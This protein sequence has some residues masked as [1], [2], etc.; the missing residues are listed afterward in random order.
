MIVADTGA[1]IAL[2]DADDR[3]HAV[4]RDL[5]EQRPSAWRIPWAVLPEADYLILTHL[6]P[7]TEQAFLDDLAE[8]RLIVDWGGEAD[9][10]RARALCA[11]YRD[12]RIG[13]VDAVVIAVAERRRA[14]SIAT[15]DL[16]HFGAVRIKGQPRLLPRDL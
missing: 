16:R 11:R 2:L 12:L 1:I 14:D 9:L 7:R 6:G 15:L 3:H 8:G 5:F 10:V 4:M 13:L